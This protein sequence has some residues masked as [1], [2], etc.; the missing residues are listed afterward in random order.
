MD[1]ESEKDTI[2]KPAGR[3]MMAL[4]RF[5]KPFVAAVNGPAVGI[6]VTLLLHCDLVYCTKEA[7]FWVPFTRIALV[8]EF[9]S[10]VTFVEACGLVRANELLLLGKKIDAKRAVENRIVCDVVEG[11]GAGIGDPFAADSIGMKVCRDLDERLFKLCHGDETASIFVSM[12]R[13]RKD[14]RE[15]LE[16]VCRE[17]LARLDE[18]LVSGDVLEAAMQ[19]NM[20]SSDGKKSKL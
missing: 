6:G 17:E 12:V 14:R 5:T 7:T 4:I 13:G 16:K 1:F 20:S 19:L 2:D 10:S 15:M 18:R 9:C 3:F 8:P 11:A